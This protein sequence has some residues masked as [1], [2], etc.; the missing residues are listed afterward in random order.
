MLHI[1]DDHNRCGPRDP[2]HQETECRKFFRL[3]RIQVYDNDRRIANVK[4]G[5]VADKPALN[6]GKSEVSPQAECDAR[7]LLEIIIRGQH[8]NFEG[9]A[10]MVREHELELLCLLATR[11]SRMPRRVSQARTVT[12]DPICPPAARRVRS[13]RPPLGLAPSWPMIEGV[14]RGAAAYRYRRW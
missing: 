1:G 12:I 11:A 5:G 13:R 10:M 14:E 9:R 2:S 4:R 6:H 8:K 3:G 7:Q